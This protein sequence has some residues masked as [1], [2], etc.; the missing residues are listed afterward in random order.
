M[1]EAA[2]MH[3][4]LFDPEVPPYP[5]GP[6]EA[7]LA[8]RELPRQAEQRGRLPPVRPGPLFLLRSEGQGPC[9]YNLYGVANHSS[10]LYS[11]H[12]TAY[13]RQPYSAEWREY[14]DSRIRTVSMRSVVSKEAYVLF[15][16]L[17]N[18]SSL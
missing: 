17:A 14:N 16:E 8:S 13:C 11:G 18:A 15:F 1:S 4:E 12:Y 10:T 7:V 6:P 3:Q 5:G 2:E 9:K